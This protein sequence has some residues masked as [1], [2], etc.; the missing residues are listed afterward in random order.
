MHIRQT[1]KSDLED[2]LSV[3]RTAFGSE[4]EAK[5][6]SD[7]L[8]DS[9]A[10]PIVSLLAYQ[11]DQPVGHILFTN[12]VLDPTQSVTASILAPL[13][14]VPGFQNQ[15]IGGKLIERGIIILERM[16]ID[17][18]FV[19]GHPTYYP[20]FGF[21]PAIPFGF[22]ASYPIPEKNHDAWMVRALSYDSKE[23]F[24]SKV[25]CADMMMKPEY[26]R[27]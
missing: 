13:A 5:L 11:A 26:W 22:D 2:I 27:E 6:V 15:G 4:E 14:V 18:V 19:L 9:S 8:S 16:G 1:E 23:N 17:L 24:N 3:E 25:I 21:E 20:K 7:L 12:A 10:E